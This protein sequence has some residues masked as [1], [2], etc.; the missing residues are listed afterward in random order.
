VADARRGYALLAVLWICAGVAALGLTVSGAGGEA[1]ASSRNRIALTAAGWEAE[2]CLALARARLLD[3]TRLDPA[4]WNRLD[5]AVRAGESRARCTLSARAVGS[6]LDVNAASQQTLAAVFRRVG[7]LGA[8]ADSAAAAIAAR[9]PF[10]S[11]RQVAAA[12]FSSLDRVLDVEPGPLALLHAA[13][14]LLAEL[15]GFGEEAVVRLVDARER[16]VPLRSFGAVSE[17]LS[18]DSRDGFDRA[19]AQLAGLVTLEPAAWV[20]TARATA[21][22]PPVTVVV[23]LRLG[24]AGDHT[25]VDRRRSWVE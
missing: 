15:P 16:G 7:I 5:Q 14:E 3:L 6:R 10:V 17:L 2:A 21:G 22:Q 20:L 1:I 8:S 18:P 4:I 25:S 11:M 24:R 23:E 12:G 13:P 19:S 9:R